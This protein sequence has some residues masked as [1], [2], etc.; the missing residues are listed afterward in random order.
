[1]AGAKQLS[2]DPPMSP[3]AVLPAPQHLCP[4]PLSSELGSGSSLP[5]P[6]SFVRIPPSHV[7]K[8]V[9]LIDTCSRLPKMHRF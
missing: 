9:I 5:T 3:P 8:S 4:F 1:M 2:T 7:A 6:A